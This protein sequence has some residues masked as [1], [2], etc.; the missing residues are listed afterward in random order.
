MIVLKGM[1]IANQ[2]AGVQEN[3]WST[4][5]VFTIL[6]NFLAYLGNFMLLSTLP[7]H[8][9]NIGENKIM[10]GLV[11]GI[12][13]LTGFIARPKIGGLLD[14]KGRKSIM[15]TSLTVLL[16]ATLS[17]NAVAYSVIL[18]LILRAIHGISWSATTTSV[19]TIASD[20][21]PASRRTEGMGFFGISNSVAIA[22]G[23]GLGLYVLEHYNYILLFLLSAFF[24]V[25]A[26]LTSLWQN[27]YLNQIST[28][29]PLIK[30]IEH[31]AGQK[32]KILVFEKTAM[33]PSFLFFIVMMTYSTVGVFLPAY[34]NE[35]GIANIGIFF[36]VSSLATIFVRLTFG[37]FADRHGS[38]KIVVSGMLLL[39]IALKLLSVAPSLPIFL[40]VAVIYGIGFGVV[41]P[42]LNALV[43]S[44]APAERRGMANATY[45]CAM[46]LGIM[47]GSV[48][49]GS[50]AQVFGFIYI[51]NV[52]AILIILSIIM[53]LVAFRGSSNE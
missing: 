41:Q 24:I 51:Y 43:I 18:L 17:Y 10:A 3:L 9:L 21:I 32:N 1:L 11:S 52:S 12:Y 6:V 23:P 7:L 47:V 4:A 37:R 20:L 14:Q 2:E 13:Y 35:K 38:S 42:T 29:P 50:V 40:I 36:I 25:L 22:L 34:A 26:L 5:F 19:S 33:W 49:W 15:L 16:L 46:D 53:Y 31:K 8:V 44:F 39:A 28:E 27:R 45:L 30:K 48:L